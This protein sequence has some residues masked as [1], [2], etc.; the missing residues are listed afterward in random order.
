M[1]LTLIEATPNDGSV[2][3]PYSFTSGISSLPYPDS[4]GQIHLGVQDP[5]ELTVSRFYRTDPPRCAGI[6]VSLLYPDSIGQIHL[7]VQGSR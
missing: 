3:Q 4:I 1:E 5:G 7:G 6:Q 2:T